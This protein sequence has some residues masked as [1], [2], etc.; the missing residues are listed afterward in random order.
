MQRPFSIST[1]AAA[2]RL[3]A[4]AAAAALTACGGGGD[5]ATTGSTTPP[6]PAPTY[7][8]A[9]NVTTTVAAGEAF[10]FSLGTQQVNV[11]ASATPVSFTTPLAS[12][13]AYTVAQVSGPRTCTLSTN[14]TGAIAANVTVSANCGAP[15]VGTALTGRLYALT[16]VQVG[17]RN[18]GAELLNVTATSATS[19]H[20]DMTTFQFPTLLAAG[21]AY[22]V[23]LDGTPAN[24][25]CSVFQGGTG[26]APAATG[27][28]RVGCETTRDLVSRSAANVSM[29]T[30]TGSQQAVIGGSNVRIG[31]A[32]GAAPLGE[33]RFVAFV[34]S[35]AAAGATGA[36][37][38]VFLR[39]RYTSQVWLVS[40]NAAGVEG[41]ADSWN[42][43]ISADGRS[44]AF[45]STA[46]NLVAGDTNGV[47]DV[48]VWTLNGSTAT[49]TRAS[50]GAGGA[51]YN[52]A[53]GQASLSGDGRV[54]AFE[55]IHSNLTTNIAGS[56]NTTVVVRRDMTAG[57]TSLISRTLTGTAADSYRPMLSEDGNRVVFYSFNA[58]LVTGDT[59]G[60][61]DLFVQD[62][63]TGTLKRV[64]LT[65]TGGE[66]NQGSESVSRMV[67]PAISGD[68][69]WVAYATTS[70]NVVPGDTNNQ[71]DVFV[72]NVDTGAVTRA[73]VASDGTQ[74]NA[75][76]PI[77][78][79][80]RLALNYDG[81]W[82]AFTSTATNLGVA[83]TTTGIPNVFMHNRVT[84]QT[85]GVT[86]NIASGNGAGPLAMSREGAYVL[87]LSSSVLDPRF[88]EGGLYAYFT[89]LKNA[90]FWAVD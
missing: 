63:T 85:R 50:V 31:G 16:G 44:V 60:L 48:F 11:T 27:A 46:S 33:G 68:G 39:D 37:R 2:L 34:S 56:D 51:Q 73:S 18:N 7:T 19:A 88:G 23:L 26:T 62:A 17:L 76:A 47:N 1:L 45:E 75:D 90:Y 30:Y 64:S 57:T 41:N 71:Q 81:T 20:Y 55:T 54:L 58:N 72:V 9:V 6:P 36:R 10:V 69:H 4:L 43:A 12:G 66:R 25:S 5:D 70:T 89:G 52:S 24:Q 61:W 77:G 15:V 42:P 38:Q 29:G 67:T 13:A 74:A 40:A 14:S 3:S 49:I 86:N 53:S 79:G 82:V 21:A 80:E 59:N 87:F 83:T 8:V 78:Q 28:V 35:A 84:G 65:S 22:T 32:T